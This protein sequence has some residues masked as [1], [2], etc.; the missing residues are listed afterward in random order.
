MEILI[1]T[2]IAEINEYKS[3]INDLNNKNIQLSNL[4]I[5]IQKNTNLNLDKAQE[6]VSSKGKIA[7]Y[8][9]E[10]EFLTQVIDSLKHKN[11]DLN[12][13]IKALTIANEKLMN[14][15]VVV[16]DNY[17]LA[18]GNQNAYKKYIKDLTTVKEK[19]ELE[20]QQYKENIDKITSDNDK[21]KESIYNLNEN[22]K[23]LEFD[24][25]NLENN[26][27]VVND[28]LIVAVNNQ[29]KK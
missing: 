14:D 11:G 5:D 18:I 6:N 4:L 29:K 12:N 10:I 1:N 28:N 3:K 8:R 15:F 27:I 13:N 24:N 25:Y 19:L 20:N 21:L 9:K 2:Y 23:A 17:K 7:N 22:V 16:T 26:F